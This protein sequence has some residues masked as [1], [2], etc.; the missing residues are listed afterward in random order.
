MSRILYAILICMFV[1][2]A[3]LVPVSSAFADEGAK[4]SEKKK[5]DK[6]GDEEP[7]CD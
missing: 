6:K 7:E 4:T 2:S 1:G 5:T 3:S